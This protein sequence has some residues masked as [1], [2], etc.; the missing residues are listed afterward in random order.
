MA[1]VG[2]TDTQGRLEGVLAT[3][4]DITSLAGLKV[5][6]EESTGFAGLVGQDPKMIAG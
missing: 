1:V 5:W 3:R 4:R 6:S 2:M